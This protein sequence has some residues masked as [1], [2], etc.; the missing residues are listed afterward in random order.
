MVIDLT[1]N[2]EPEWLHEIRTQKHVVLNRSIEKIIEF[3]DEKDNGKHNDRKRTEEACKNLCENPNMKS[4]TMYGDFMQLLSKECKSVLFST[5]AVLGNVEEICVG[6]TEIEFVEVRKM[7][8]MEGLEF[9]KLHDSMIHN[10]EQEQVY[11]YVLDGLKH[12]TL[13]KHSIHLCA[14]S[15]IDKVMNGNVDIKPFNSLNRCVSASKNVRSA[16][17]AQIE[18]R[19][20]KYRYDKKKEVTKKAEY[21]RWLKVLKEANFSKLKIAGLTHRELKRVYEKHSMEGALKNAGMCEKEIAKL[22]PREMKRRYQKLL[23]AIGSE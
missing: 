2:D 18:K 20:K 17:R 14:T 21:E 4:L 22:K 10:I 19:Y 11:K 12:R 15:S 6:D 16:T 3:G 1:G 23:E 8:M 7:M 9:F 5:V 13:K